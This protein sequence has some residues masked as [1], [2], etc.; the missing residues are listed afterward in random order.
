MWSFRVFGA[1]LRPGLSR[2]KAFSFVFYAAGAWLCV[3]LLP[4]SANLKVENE[5]EL[6]T[7]YRSS[8]VACGA[9]A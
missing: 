9:S 2:F 4:D 5:E 3:E 7:F 1:G 8:V 6:G